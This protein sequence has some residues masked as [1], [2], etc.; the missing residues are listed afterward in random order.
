M[1]PRYPYDLF[2]AADNADWATVQALAAQFAEGDPAANGRWPGV[3]CAGAS[4]PL[5]AVYR[6]GV[7]QLTA[8][9]REALRAI[10]GSL[11]G[12]ILYE[13]VD[14]TGVIADFSGPVDPPA[15]APLHL[16]AWLAS[17][18]LVVY[19]PPMPGR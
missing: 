8:A 2:V 9:Q 11:P 15:P 14:S 19:T 1:S 5:A 12:G 7:M 6:A 18:N 3:R 17:L 16:R 4:A 10:A 13:L